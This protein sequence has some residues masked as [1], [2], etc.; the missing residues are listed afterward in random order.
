MSSSLP[1][2]LPATPSTPSTPPA[3]PPVQFS[4]AAEPLEPKKPRW[5]IV[6][7]TI[8]MV[9][10]GMGLV[11][12]VELMMSPKMFA[13][14]K[15]VMENMQKDMASTRPGHRNPGQ[16]P[17]GF[18]KVFSDL[19]DTPEW[20]GSWCLIGGMSGMLVSGLYGVS[21]FRLLKI[22]RGAVGLFY[23]ATGL[24]MAYT[25]VQVGV[26]LAMMSM[27]GMLLVGSGVIGGIIDVVL[28]SVVANKDKEMFNTQAF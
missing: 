28:I 2:E 13:Q 15:Q 14:Q 9:F 6:V 17:K 12:G 22:K 1:P 8:V 24:S 19:Y 20:F 4:G 26:G 18:F 21:G 11:G 23:L 25:L 3:P 7:G 16:P 10:G 27:L 5:H